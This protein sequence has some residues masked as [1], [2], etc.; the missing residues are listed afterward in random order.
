MKPE[1]TTIVALHVHDQSY[2]SGLMDIRDDEFTLYEQYIIG[3]LVEE[4]DD[5]Y[6]LAQDQMPETHSVRHT[7]AVP[8]ADVL[9][10]KRFEYET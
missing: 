5:A 9:S 8:K 2:F 7:V 10:V 4:R 1:L 6:V 3:W